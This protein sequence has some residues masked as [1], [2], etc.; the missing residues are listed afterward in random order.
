MPEKQGD[1]FPVIKEKKRD[2]NNTKEKLKK[3]GQ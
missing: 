3:K 2:A 1:L